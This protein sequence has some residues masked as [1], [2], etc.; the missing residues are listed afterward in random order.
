MSTYSNEDLS[1]EL[2]DLARLDYDAIEAYRAAI[3]RLQSGEYRRRLGEFMKDHERHTTEL[4]VEVRALGGIPDDGPGGLRML[5][6][7]AV[8]MGTLGDDKGILHAMNTNEAVINRTYESALEKL[9]GYPVQEVVA[10]NR[11][12]ERRHKAWIEAELRKD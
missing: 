7:G 1:D 11:E 6:E 8:R 12:D 9:E 10:R 2:N 5:S 3:E 4:A